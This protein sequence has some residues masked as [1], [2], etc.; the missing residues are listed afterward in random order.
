[1]T[2]HLTRGAQ[3]LSA[4]VVYNFHQACNV[5]VVRLHRTAC[6]DKDDLVIFYD[7]L[8]NKWK[9]VTRLEDNEPIFFQQILLRL[10]NVLGESKK[11]FNQNI[12]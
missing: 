1:M 12:A 3:A 6:T 5:I 9:E 7:P 2:I 11:V 4:S 8:D 10:S